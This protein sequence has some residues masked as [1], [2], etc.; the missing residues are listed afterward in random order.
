MRE[1]EMR[2]R[3]VHGP[4]EL[5][6]V[7]LALLVTPGNRR[8]LRA[9]RDETAGLPGAALLREHVLE[10]PPA[11]RLPWFELFAERAAARP[12]SERQALVAAARRVMG[13]DGLVRAPDR[14]WWLLL[15]RRLG[16]A[17]PR[18]LHGESE[19]DLHALGEAQ[20]LAIAAFSAFLSRMV[21]FPEVDVPVGMPVAHIGERWYHGVMQRWDGRV[22]L[23]RREL[24][25]ADAMLRALRSI[26][27]LPWLIKPL[28]LRAW[29]EEAVGIVAASGLAIHLSAADALRICS[30]LLDCPRPPELASHHMEPRRGP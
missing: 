22:A 29:T 19:N 30:G 27:T 2:L 23:P 26:Q 24:P 4:L 1:L 16:E 6:A 5:R 12:R 17:P 9:W 28:L 21:P 14:L 3:R 18:T 15:R 20:V 25:D 7:L 10:L 13:A 8:E 11:A